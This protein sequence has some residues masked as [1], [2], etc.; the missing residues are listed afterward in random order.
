[1]ANSITVTARELASTEGFRKSVFFGVLTTVSAFLTALF[2]DI[3]VDYFYSVLVLDSMLM[4]F[5]T[6]FIGKNS[7][8]FDVRGIIFFDFVVNC[9]AA[10]SFYIEAMNWVF[11][12][13]LPFIKP[14]NFAL[15]T[16]Y[17]ARI[18][19]HFRDETGRYYAFPPFDVVRF[20][21]G[22]P[23]TGRKLPL[24]LKVF[25]YI[26]IIAALITGPIL[27]LHDIK[28][29]KFAIYC[30]P[31]FFGIFW[32]GRHE[33][34]VDRLYGDHDKMANAL[35]ETLSHNE[36]LAKERDQQAKEILLLKQQANQQAEALEAIK[37]VVAE[38]AERNAALQ[39]DNAA[40]QQDTAAKE[41]VIAQ[42]TQTMS[43][44]G[45]L[46]SDKISMLNNYDK[47][48]RAKKNVMINLFKN[49]L[50]FVKP[51]L[52]LVGKKPK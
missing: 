40:L 43:A 24:K 49:Y 36:I 7:F 44:V 31:A 16:L 42:L 1:M 12:M 48:P 9:I 35:C 27:I 14:C 51:A 30:V 21:L 41:E 50:Y 17:L 3:S 13:L 6:C 4:L 33:R 37:Q 28:A 5:V 19:W 20:L 11:D 34:E 15:F 46:D 45:T 29:I 32:L 38:H 18:A 22:Q 10:Y 39:Q 23:Y 52:K 25:G 2:H 8:A 26:L 47:L